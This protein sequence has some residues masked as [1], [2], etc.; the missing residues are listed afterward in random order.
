MRK[1]LQTVAVAALSLGGATAWANVDV[2]FV[3]PEEFVDIG[4]RISV[5]TSDDT[6]KFISSALTE[7]A[8]AILLPGQDMKIVVKDVDL[9]GDVRPVGHMMDNIRIIK[10]LYR[11]SMQFSYTITQ[12]GK[13]VREG[14]ADIQDM[15]FM[16]HYNRYFR[17]DPLYYEKPMIDAWFDKEFGPPAKRVSALK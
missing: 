6:L 9:A 15:G 7:R 2:Q 5:R 16:D 11:P 10:Q 14:S 1:H 4:N 3:K 13:M 12:D 8:N 17:S